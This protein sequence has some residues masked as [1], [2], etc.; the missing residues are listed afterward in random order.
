A[1][2]FDRDDGRNLSGPDHDSTQMGRL[3]LRADWFGGKGD[4]ITVQGDLYR[5]QV[6]QVQPS[7]IL[8]GG[9]GPVPQPPFTADLSGGNLLGR[10]RRALSPSSDFTLQVYYDRTVRDD[11]FFRDSLDTLDADLQHRFTL[12]QNHEILWGL[13]ARLMFDEFLG[14]SPVVLDPPQKTDRLYSGFV[15]DQIQVGSSL[16]LVLGGKIEHKSLR[17]F[18][19]QPS[20]RV[21]W[22]LTA[23]Q[24]LWAAVSR[25]VRTPTRVD[26]DIF[27]PLSDP[28]MNPRIALVGNPDLDSEEMTAF[29]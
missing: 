21:S 9:L 6:D 13:S 8:N 29:E 3:G 14:Q 24:N 16:R 2:G 25:A 18:E 1:K 23:H 26:R 4:T 11:P 19:V 10:W 17:G 22:D 7:I 20:G 28:R 15:Q 5:G 12:G 27:A